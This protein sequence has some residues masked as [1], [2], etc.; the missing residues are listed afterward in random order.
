MPFFDSIIVHVAFAEIIPSLFLFDS[1]LYIYIQLIFIVCA[2]KH[3]LHY[4]PRNYYILQ[5]DL[6]E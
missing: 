5:V 3:H 4:F 1:L 2:F 6:E